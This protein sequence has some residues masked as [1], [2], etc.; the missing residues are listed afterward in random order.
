MASEPVNA[1]EQENETPNVPASAED[2]KAAAALSNLDS[3]GTDDDVVKKDVDTE[4]LGKAMQN[5]D[6]KGKGEEKAAKIK[7]E[8]ADVKLLVSGRSWCV[9]Y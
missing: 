7:V 3:R 1:N 8:A 5:L 4:A 6:V 2:R 9:R